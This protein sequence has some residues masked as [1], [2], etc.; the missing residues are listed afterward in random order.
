MNKQIGWYYLKEDK[1]FCDNGYE[2]AAWYENI[3][4]KAGRYPITVVD[5]RVMHFDDERRAKFNGQI[6]GHIGSAYVTFNGTIVSDYF[7]SMFCGVPVGTYDCEK[8]KGQPSRYTMHIYLYS[9]AKD[10][11]KGSDEY[12][13]FPEYEVRT[14]TYISDYD[15]KE[16]TSYDVFVKEQEEDTEVDNEGVYAEF[17][18]ER[19]WDV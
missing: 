13:L 1:V 16:H 17:Y 3:A 8:N 5:Y 6:D 9:L 7:G 11:Y 10:V 2:C 15:G 4:V 19:N 18:A 14:E 12:E